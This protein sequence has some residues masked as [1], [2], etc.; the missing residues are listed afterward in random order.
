M[1]FQCLDWPPL[2]KEWNH[3]SNSCGHTNSSKRA[4]IPKNET[5]APLHVATLTAQRELQSI[6]GFYRLPY[7]CTKNETIRVVTLT[8]QRELLKYKA[9]RISIPYLPGIKPWLHFMWPHIQSYLM[10]STPHFIVYY[11]VSP[12]PPSSLLISLHSPVH[13][14]LCSEFFPDSCSPH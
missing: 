9:S 2:V 6:Q 3:G 8:A 5:M 11:N 10:I 4:S 7:L 13:S 1:D 12:S 14:I